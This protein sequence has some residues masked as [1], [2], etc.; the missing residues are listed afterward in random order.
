[1]ALRMRIGLLLGTVG[2]VGL[3]GQIG[4]RQTPEPTRPARPDFDIRDASAPG[5]ASARALAELAA[6]NRTRTPGAPRPPRLHPHTG[7]IRVLD[8]PGWFAV[9]GAPA[10]ALRELLQQASERLGLDEQDLDGLLLARDYVSRS[11]GLRHVTFT[12]TVDGLPVFGGMNALHVAADGAIVRVTSSAAPDA[13]VKLCSRQRP[14]RPRQRQ[15][16]IPIR[17]SSQRG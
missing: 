16:S 17:P 14:P 4:A 6:A 7:G 11:T 9:P 8:A 1:M 10:T 3:S 2:I 13:S 5:P 15:T 12:Q